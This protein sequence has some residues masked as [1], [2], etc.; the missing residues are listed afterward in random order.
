MLKFLKTFASFS[1][2]IALLASPSLV[3]AAT[4]SE[5]YTY[6]FSPTVVQNLTWTHDTVT[7]SQT[8]LDTLIKPGLSQWNGLSSKVN[9]N[10]LAP[11]ATPTKVKVIV[12]GNISGQSAAE[13]VPACATGTGYGVCAIDR[14]HGSLY[15]SAKIYG[16][17]NAMNSSGFTN[18]NKIKVY[19]HEMGHVLSM[20][21]FVRTDLPPTTSIM[22][23]GQFTHTV[24]P[25]D[26]EN[27]T[28]KWGT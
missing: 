10:Y 2:G 6:G 7:V 15:T 1:T 24:Q 13:T 11:S 25:Y 28:G 5:Y 9:V 26:K 27:F 14:T 21:H 8:Y 3:Y 12:T 22:V 19:A 17:D 18:A 20:D 16:Y 4:Q 23:Q